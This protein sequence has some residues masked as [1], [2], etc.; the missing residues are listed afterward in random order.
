M[1]TRR[2]GRLTTSTTTGS[3]ELGSDALRGTLTLCSSD[4]HWYATPPNYALTIQ[5]DRGWNPKYSRM[6]EARY[7]LRGNTNKVAT[8]EYNEIKF[9]HCDF[10][11]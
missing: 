3:V 8:K 5:V 7:N 4:C 2:S 1:S 10:N 9:T 6:Y 11:T